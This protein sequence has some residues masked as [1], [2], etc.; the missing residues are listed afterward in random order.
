ATDEVLARFLQ[1]TLDLVRKDL[2]IDAGADDS[3]ANTSQGNPLPPE[4]P[5][6][7]KRPKTS[8]FESFKLYMALGDQSAVAEQLYQ[9]RSKQYQVSR[10]VAAV[11]AYFMQ[12]GVSKERWTKESENPEVLQWSPD[13]IE[14]GKRSDGLTDRQKERFDDP[15]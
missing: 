15:D 10:D 13:Q 4:E 12:L 2:E 6:S 11:E 8:A 9:S 7:I 3:D 14:L 5:A 1:N